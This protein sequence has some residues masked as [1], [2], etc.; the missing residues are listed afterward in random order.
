M[1][2]GCEAIA[3]AVMAGLCAQ[4]PEF[5]TRAPDKVP[6][7]AT[8]LNGTEWKDPPLAPRARPVALPFAVAA[9]DSRKERATSNAL[10]RLREELRPK[11]K[12]D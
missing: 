2:Q 1:A 10:D 4:M 6:H 12:P 7:P 3:D 5:S 8:W 11:V 9:E